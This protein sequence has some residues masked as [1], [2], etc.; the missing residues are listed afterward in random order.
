MT[1]RRNRAR[2][3]NRKGQPKMYVGTYNRLR[4]HVR[5]SNIDVIRAARKKIKPQ[6]RKARAQ[7][8]ARLA[9]SCPE[10]GAGIGD[11]AR[12]APPGRP[13]NLHHAHG[14]Q[15]RIVRRQ[16]LGIVAGGGRLAGHAAH[17]QLGGPEVRRIAGVRA[18]CR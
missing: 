10:G 1:T 17:A 12:T 7:R 16:Q 9:R 15:G 6:F 8:D 13:R 14:P 2:C 11:I 18:T 3:L 4:V 5:A